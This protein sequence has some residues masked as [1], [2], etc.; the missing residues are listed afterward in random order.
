MLKTFPSNLL[1][2]NEHWKNQNLMTLLIIVM[3]LITVLFALCLRISTVIKI[4]SLERIKLNDIHS[5]MNR[6]KM[7][8]IMTDL[9]FS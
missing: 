2:I 3:F 4:D 8:T 1:I 7:D 5:Y 6:H 9:M